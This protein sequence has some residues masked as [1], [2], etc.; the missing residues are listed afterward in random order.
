MSADPFPTSH[1]FYDCGYRLHRGL[2]ELS[3]A[4]ERFT[5]NY[6][7]EAPGLAQYVRDAIHANTD[8]AGK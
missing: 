8:R 4:D 2:G 1:W 7:R 5:A 6:D 3:V